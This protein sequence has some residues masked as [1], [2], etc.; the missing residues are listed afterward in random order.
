[1]SRQKDEATT[2]IRIY[3][4][5]C[6]DRYGHDPRGVDWQSAA[7]QR[8][9]F[10]AVLAVGDLD[11]ATL[12]DAGCGLGDFYGY[13]R[14]RGIAARYTGCDLS[15]PH[16]EAARTAHPEARFVAA[17]VR[18]ILAG[19]RFDYVL[20]CGLLHLRVPR[21]NRWAWSIVRAMYDGCL[22]GVAF[23]LPRR[24]AGHPPV[25]AAVDPADWLARLR[26]LA[27][28]VEA[29]PLDP[30]GDTVFL[31]RKHTTYPP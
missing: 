24:E 20:G 28:T 3:F 4:G 8:A 7:A 12:L 18:E 2:R 16:V 10:A 29:H 13:L 23:T 27:P 31:L 19:E 11:G 15:T 26:T 30:W 25:L 5:A 17:D 14:E 1:M 9:R 6:L 21:W 22:R